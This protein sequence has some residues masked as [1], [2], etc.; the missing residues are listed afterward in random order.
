MT[1]VLIV[2]DEFLVALDLEDIVCGA[3]FGV[4]GIAPDKAAAE[5]LG[6]GS[7]IALVDINLRDG[8]TGPD[9]AR[10]LADR[11]TAIIYVTA[12]PS[13]VGQPAA[14][15]IGIVQKPYSPDS[16]RWALM[17][18]ANGT[19]HEPPPPEFIPLRAVA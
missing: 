7:G 14:T 16:I 5:A 9:I 11:G 3:G 17:V 18:A 13:Q 19:T 4:R 2:E 8:P 10:M 15:A 12:N 6:P 1:P